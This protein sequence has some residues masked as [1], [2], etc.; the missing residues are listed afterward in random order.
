MTASEF[1]SLMKSRG[2]VLHG[3]AAARE[4]DLANTGLRIRR[5][6]MMPAAIRELY[7]IAGG[8]EMGAGYIFGPTDIDRGR[9]Y[10]VPS[11]VRINDEIA[12][13]GQ[14]T[15]GKTIFGRNDLFFFAFDAFGVF[16]MLDNLSLRPMKKYD[17]A[18][19]AMSDCLVGGRF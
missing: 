12:A 8:I 7:A 1:V 10:P 5:C 18:W 17:D 2:A 11:I 16:Y 15:D 6:A 3:P 4:V 9:E 14:N 13:T 19:R